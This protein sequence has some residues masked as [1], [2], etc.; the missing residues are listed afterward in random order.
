MEPD[1]GTP[2]PDHRRS[3]AWLLSLAGAVPF[4]TAALAQWLLSDHGFSTWSGQ[5]AVLYGAIILSFLGGI[6]WGLG[7]HAGSD[8]SRRLAVSVLPALMGWLALLVQPAI[9]LLLL[10]AGFAGQFI[11]DL[12]LGLPRWFAWLRATITLIVLGSLAALTVV[13]WQ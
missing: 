3:L 9:G 10:C 4:V 2:A 11:T 5:A 1:S 6:H 7:L 12:W 8:A 13:A